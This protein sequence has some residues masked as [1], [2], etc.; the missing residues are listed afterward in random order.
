MSEK[1]PSWQYRGPLVL[2]IA[3]AWPMALKFYPIIPETYLLPLVQIEDPVVYMKV[4][5][6]S[7]S[8]SGAGYR[9]IECII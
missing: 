2:L 5:W 7:G 4:K 1:G 3:S 8:Q 9:T 6:H